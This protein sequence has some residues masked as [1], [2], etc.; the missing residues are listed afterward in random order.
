MG[1]P[2]PVTRPL[3]WRPLTGAAWAVGKSARAPYLARMIDDLMRRFF[4]GKPEAL[5]QTSKDL[6]LAALM[7]RLARADHFYSADE[8]DHVE[9]V[10]MRL[11]GI[12]RAAARDMRERAE[13]LEEAAPDTVR[14][15]RA[16]KDGVALE[17]RIH[18]VEALWTV[19]L[20]D[21]ARD[22][23]EDRLMRLVTQLLGISDVDSGLAR[24]RAERALAR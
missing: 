16:L 14:F 21:G 17:D 8:V 1:S 10:L 15:T 19:A 22:A 2:C 13:K 12:S 23:Q 5:S 24:Q 4:G 3:P 7:V 18:L 20:S 9:Q 6:A 11:E